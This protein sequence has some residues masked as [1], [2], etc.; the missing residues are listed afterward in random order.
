MVK[1]KSKRIGDDNITNTYS[2]QNI[3][4]LMKLS[5]LNRI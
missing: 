5:R 3:G 4:G 1:K 2:S